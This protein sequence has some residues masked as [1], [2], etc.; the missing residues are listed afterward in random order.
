[1]DAADREQLL[2]N[3]AD[4]VWQH[5]KSGCATDPQPMAAAVAAA[6]KAGISLQEI[7]D[8]NAT[9]TDRNDL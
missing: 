3:A 6:R 1:M 9:R 8:Y 2:K 4:L 7:A 5:A